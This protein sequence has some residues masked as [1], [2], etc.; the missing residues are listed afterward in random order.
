MNKAA[1]KGPEGYIVALTNEEMHS[2]RSKIST[3]EV[4]GRGKYSKYNAKAFTEKGLY[5]LATIL[6]RDIQKI[7]KSRIS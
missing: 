4:Q 6:K 1:R 5:M 3:L 2:I 7:V